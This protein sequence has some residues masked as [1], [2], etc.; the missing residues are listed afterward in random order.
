M[1]RMQS[2][3]RVLTAAEWECFRAGLGPVRDWTEDELIQES[4]PFEMGVALFDH[5]SA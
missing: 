3:D 4:D 1:W 2:G 5:L